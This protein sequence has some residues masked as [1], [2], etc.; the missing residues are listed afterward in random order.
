MSEYTYSEKYCAHEAFHDTCLFCGEWAF[1][2]MVELRYSHDQLRRD[3]EE[4]RAEVT[5]L[6]AHTMDQDNELTDLE[7]RLEEAR[8]LL[9]WY[10]REAHGRSAPKKSCRECK[11]TGRYTFE[12]GH[13]GD[14]VETD[15]EC[16]YWEDQQVADAYRWDGGKRA[17][18]FLSRTAPGGGSDE[19]A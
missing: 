10:A 3:L 14:E 12:N 1:D 11:G 7:R 9:A 15:C 2:N 17:R 18:A 4:A 5:T 16:T 6:M 19:R 8:G 13:N